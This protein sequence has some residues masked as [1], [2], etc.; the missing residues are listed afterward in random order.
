MSVVYNGSHSIEINGYNTWTH[1]HLVPASR[2]YVVPAPPN[3]NIVQLPG[4]DKFIDLTD[5]LP[6]GLT[7]QQRSGSWEFYID[8]DKWGSWSVAYN[9]ISD[10]LHGKKVTV[11][12]VDDLTRQY[13]GRISV[14]YSPDQNYSKIVLNYTLYPS[15]EHNDNPIVDPSI[16][17]SQQGDGLVLITSGSARIQDSSNSIGTPSVG[18]RRITS[19]YSH[20]FDSEGDLILYITTN[21]DNCA[22][23]YNK[24]SNIF[25]DSAN[26]G[27][28]SLKKDITNVVTI[29]KSDVGNTSVYFALGYI[30]KD[31]VYVAKISMYKSSNSASGSQGQAQWIID[32]TGQLD[33][34]PPEQP[35][36]PLP[37]G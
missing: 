4:T 29:T 17:P 30:G 3:I 5:I 37:E 14:Q 18:F 27:V 22:I 36:Q 35:D 31:S 16:D 11:R 8:H 23:A 2:P 24:Y 32:P 33:P 19:T 28:I 34:V 13:S 7:H 15:F 9:T 1:W 26:A 6:G 12:L 10:L 20:N 21:I 25:T